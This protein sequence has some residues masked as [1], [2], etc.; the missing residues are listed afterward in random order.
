[1]MSLPVSGPMILSTQVSCQEG[2][3]SEGGRGSFRRGSLA[4]GSLS[5]DLPLYGRTS[6]WYRAP[7]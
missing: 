7:Y 5:G 3:L 1:M 4:G 2:D 6:G